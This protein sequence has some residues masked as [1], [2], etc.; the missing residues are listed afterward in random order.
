MTIYGKVY[1]VYQKLDFKEKSFLPCIPPSILKRL[2]HILKGYCI[3][4]FASCH[5]CNTPE[6]DLLNFLCDGIFHKLLRDK[7]IHLKLIF[8]KYFQCF[9][10]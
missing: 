7:F 9:L 10:P 1:S 4:T 3:M 5:N 8:V 2:S 6:L